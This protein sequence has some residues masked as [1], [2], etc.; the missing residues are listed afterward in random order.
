MNINADGSFYTPSGALR[1]GSCP[2][3]N[4]IDKVVDDNHAVCYSGH[5]FELNPADGR[6]KAESND[7][8]TRPN[9]IAWHGPRKDL[10]NQ[11]KAFELADYEVTSMSVDWND[12]NLQ[13]AK[14]DPGR[15]ILDRTV[16]VIATRTRRK[17]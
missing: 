16:V 11:L 3:G 10:D 17:S 9:Q 1:S 8:G 2:C 6:T 5:Y 4:G 12:P 13:N 14:G 7:P 15:N